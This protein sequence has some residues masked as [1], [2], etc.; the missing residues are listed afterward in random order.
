MKAKF[1]S[2]VA[3]VADMSLLKERLSL[4]G[5]V[6]AKELDDEWKQLFVEESKL[7]CIF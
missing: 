1:P 2:H 4:I 3:L 7:S 5:N 6:K